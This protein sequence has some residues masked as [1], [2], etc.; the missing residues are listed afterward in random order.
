LKEGCN[1][2]RT[3]REPRLEAGAGEGKRSFD[4]RVLMASD[5]EVLRAAPVCPRLRDVCLVVKSWAVRLRRDGEVR[6]MGSDLPGLATI[7]QVS[8][9]SL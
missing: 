5:V 6:Q 3:R 8:K 1:G 4:E 9:T 2:V 7:I